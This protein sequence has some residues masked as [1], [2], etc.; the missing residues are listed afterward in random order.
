MIRTWIADVRPLYEEEK[1]RS[2]Y[3]ALPDFRKEKAD[4]IRFQADKALSVGAWSLWKMICKTYGISET[5]VFNL[6]HSGDYAL[7]SVYIGDGQGIQVGCDIEA[8]A[9]AKLRIAKRFFCNSEY[10]TICREEDLDRQK[11]VFCRVW[12]LKESFMK[13]TR[14]GM[15]LGMNSFEIELS[16][17]PIL[18]N[19]PAR[20]PDKYQ[21]QEYQ[22]SNVPYKIAVCTNDDE[23]D[24]KIRMEL[25]L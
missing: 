6:S 12:V 19:K 4:R 3:K 15:A 7:C 14:E 18:L 20:F 23:I 21:Y 1:Y 17:P 22:I 5:S 9:N 8:T 11:E 10:E 25:K 24:S 16:N 2:Y 13:A